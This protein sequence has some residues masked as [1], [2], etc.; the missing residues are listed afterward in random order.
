MNVYSQIAAN[1]R[2]TYFFLAGF[3]A[4]IALLAYVFGEAYGS[5][6]SFA[7][8]ALIISGV[9]GFGSYYFSDKIIL[10]MTG[11]RLADRKRDF[12]LVT[13]AEN[14]AIA[15]GL[16]KPRVY[17]IDD[18]APNAFATGRDPE[19]AVVAATT[20]LIGRLNRA[21][22][23]G[24]IAHEMA[25]VKNYDIR[26][27][28]VVTVLA[29]VVV[30]MVDIF[31]RSMWFGGG[32]KSGRGGNLGAILLVVGIILAVLS[33]ILATV[34]KLSIS[35]KREFLADASGSYLTRNPDALANA[36]EKIASDPHRM[37][38]ASNA[39][40]HLFFSNPFKKHAKGS[41]FASL[42]NTHPPMEERVK[43]L[44]TM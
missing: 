18:P 11:A 3:I 29:G 17:V 31:L 21:E 34:M 41:R 13:V 9:M 20:G 37:K 12:H 1:K 2:K 10:S 15:S 25:H 32:R 40:A 19:H 26:L 5:G 23:E 39:T 16:P 33:P 44:R 30:L 24:V 6:L 14:M 27:M 7:G 8:I 28:A 43:R 35:R 36:L 38:N 22:L 42:F 4:F